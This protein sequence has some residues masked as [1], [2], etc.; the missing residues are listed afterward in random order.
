[1]LRVYQMQQF[2]K[3]RG[4]RLVAF[5]DFTTLCCNDNDEGVSLV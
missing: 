2:V 4:R 1:M 3:L 5:P